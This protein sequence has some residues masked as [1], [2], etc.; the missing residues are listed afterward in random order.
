MTRLHP[1]AQPLR[2]A[3]WPAQGM[4]LIVVLMV[5][6]VVSIVGLAAMQI[7]IQGARAARNDRD[8]QIARQAAEAALLDA[9][10]DLEGWAPAVAAKTDRSALFSSNANGAVFVAGCSTSGTALGLCLEAGGAGKPSWMVVDLADSS[11][12]SV[13]FGTFT[14]RHISAQGLGVQPAKKPRYLIES[15]PDYG[16]EP[17]AGHAMGRAYRITAI[18]FGPHEKTTVV[19][20]VVYR[21]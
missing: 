11:G 4:S 13:E 5:V 10:F 7:G 6:S 20:Q 2:L 19:L 15:I 21:K 3:R 17:N 18:G 9:E 1:F 14:G 12:A 16:A 8:R